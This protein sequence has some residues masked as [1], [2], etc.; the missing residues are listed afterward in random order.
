MSLVHKLKCIFQYF[1]KITEKGKRCI[2]IDIEID[3]DRYLF[4]L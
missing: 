2:T 3:M 1:D 4:L